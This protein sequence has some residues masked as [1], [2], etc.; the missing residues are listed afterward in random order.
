MP[1]KNTEVGDVRTAAPGDADAA[2]EIETDT[3]TVEIETKVTGRNGILRMCRNCAV[4]ALAQFI[5][6]SGANIVTD[7]LSPEPAP[8]QTTPDAP[9]D[10]QDEQNERVAQYEHDDAEPAVVAATN[11]GE[12]GEEP[13]AAAEREQERE[14]ELESGLEDELDRGPTEVQEVRYLDDDDKEVDPDLIIQVNRRTRQQ[15]RMAR[16]ADDSPVDPAHPVWVPRPVAESG[17]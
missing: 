10:T 12:T 7:H 4:H 1:E 5:G 14:D 3:A 15:V 6:Y 8:S 2:T 9:F 16:V 13:G 17:W 11:E